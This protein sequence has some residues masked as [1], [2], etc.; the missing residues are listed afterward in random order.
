MARRKGIVAFGMNILLLS[1]LAN[2]M[3]IENG[4]AT[5]TTIYVDDSNTAGPWDG[6]Q[7]FPYRTI[8]QG[9]TAASAGGTVFVYSGTYNENV[10]ITKDLTLRGENKD[11]TFID[12]GGNG[13]VLNAHK[14]ADTNI[15]V[16]IS[17]VTI[18]NAGIRDDCVIFSNVANGEISDTKILNCQDGAGLY[19]LSC[20]AVIIHDNVVTDVEGPGIYL[21]M[22]DQNTIENNIIQNNQKGIQLSFS[23]NNHITGNTIRDNSAYGIYVVQSSNNVFSLNDFNGDGISGNGQNAQDSSTNSWSDNNQGNY[24]EDYNK[25]DNNSDGIGDTPY[26]IPGG[27]NLDNYTLGYF[28][29]PEQPNGGNQQPVA[30]SLSISK[31][32]AHY[33]ELITFTGQGIDSDGSIVG[34]NWRSNLNGTLSTTQ[35]FST[36][37]LAIGTHTIYFKVQDDDGAWSTERTGSITIN[38]L[39]NNLP[40]AYIDEIA[41]NPAQQGQPVRFQ[42]HGLDQDGTIIGYKWL[43]SKDG[44][45]STTSTFNKSNLSLGTHTIYFQVK[46]NTNDLS[47][48][49]SMVLVIEK[50]SSQGTTENHPPTADIGGP[51]QGKTHTTVSFNASASND[52]DGDLI[53]YLWNYGDNYGGTGVVAS[54]TYSSPGTYTVTLTVTDDDGAN[55]TTFTTVVIS[56]S[57]SQGDKPGTI[58]GISLEI[59]FPVLIVVVVLIMLGIL[60]GFILRMRRR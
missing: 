53:S 37:T 42:G 45:I 13:H 22:S 44:V 21:T 47:P 2:V 43:S 23:S 16:S 14:L 9:I 36:T 52:D 25:Y 39:T 30:V 18:R 51:Y 55:A 27:N 60:T 10:V 40:I 38:R 57:A 28:K 35:S 49:V 59:P 8:N 6:T 12:G 58:A 4:H 54:H 34:Y 46:D 41:P 48:S 33:G 24:W 56:Q 1:I 17:Q 19:L 31:T 20:Y 7:D 11:T 15:Q 50:N 32:T 29:Q 3:L 26:V 5:E